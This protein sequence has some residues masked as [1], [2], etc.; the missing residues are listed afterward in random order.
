MI[1]SKQGRCLALHVLP[2]C[3]FKFFSHGSKGRGVGLSGQH[4][5]GGPH[6]ARVLPGLDL[7]PPGHAGVACFSQGHPAVLLAFGRLLGGLP[8]RSLAPLAS[9]EE[10]FF[11]GYP[12]KGLVSRPFVLL[13]S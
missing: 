13:T 5:G 9:G 11:S 7:T 8:D 4:T 6:E 3:V 12:V 1:C 2:R 10:V